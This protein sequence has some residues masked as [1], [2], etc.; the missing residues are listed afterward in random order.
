[1]YMC[2]MKYP[3]A[4]YMSMYICFA[5]FHFWLVVDLQLASQLAVD[6]QTF[7]AQVW[8]SQVKL[9]DIGGCVGFGEGVGGWD[10]GKANHE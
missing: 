2:N 7:A 10:L 6:F 8:A 3:C 1:M 4:Q 9:I 5:S